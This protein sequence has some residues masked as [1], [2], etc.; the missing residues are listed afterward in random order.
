MKYLRK[1]I[2]LFTLVVFCPMMANAQEQLNAELIGDT[3][4]YHSVLPLDED[5][6]LVTVRGEGN[7]PM[8]LCRM[9]TDGTELEYVPQPQLIEQGQ[10]VGSISLFRGENNQLGIVYH[11]YKAD[12][13]GIAVGDISESLI[14]NETGAVWLSSIGVDSPY[15]MDPQYI[16]ENDSTFAFSFLANGQSGL[17]FHIVRFDKWGNVLANRSFSSV[18][19]DF[20]RLFTLN[21]DSTGYLVGGMDYNN[22][23]VTHTPCYNL[24][25]NL[26]TT[27]L[28][29]EI[30]WDFPLPGWRVG[31]FYPYI[32]KH[33]KTGCLYVVGSLG[34][35]ENGQQ[36]HQNAIIAKFDRDMSHIE[37]WKMCI[38]SPSD[39]QR[40]YIKSIDFFSDGS[41]AVC[42]SVKQGFYFARY[43]EDLN[44][45]SEVY[46]YLGNSPVVGPMEVCAMPNGEGLV[47]CSNDRIYYI[48]A[49][50]LWSIEE[51]HEA[52]FAV[53]IAYPNPG[54]STL[55]IRTGLQKA[56]VEVY[57]ALG[58]KVHRQEITEN[59]TAI[60]A[61]SWPSGVYVWKVYANGSEAESG[62]WVKE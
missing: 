23:P 4:G 50:S 42:A 15:V 37:K 9:R 11:K 62:K 47:T 56:H 35:D 28:H 30:Y 6:V 46:V 49:D 31:I 18:I 20:D 25:F 39:D 3:R 12:S 29:D 22:Q 8:A 32:A 33:P 26:D 17:Q 41:I 21:A 27:L 45:L 10:T 57:D 40:A 60:D 54:G 1:Y 19:V 53:A 51:A 24:D 7:G 36:V 38:D 16:I 43:D 61:E 58:R 59:I 34:W 44:K 13:L 55:N 48:P 5:E 52:G 2:W 14:V